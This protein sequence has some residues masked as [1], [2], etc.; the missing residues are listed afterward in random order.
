MLKFSGEG[1]RARKGAGRDSAASNA[2]RNKTITRIARAQFIL[3]AAVPVGTSEIE[4]TTIDA[5][6]GTIIGFTASSVRVTGSFRVSATLESCP[7][8]NEI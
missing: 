7:A 4:Y 2:I 8:V 1:S 6:N 5:E 3:I